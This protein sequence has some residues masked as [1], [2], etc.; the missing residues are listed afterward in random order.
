MQ[1][2][3]KVTSLEYGHPILFLEFFELLAKIKCSWT[4]KESRASHSYK[5]W[6]AL[7]LEY[8]HRN[9]QVSTAI[10]T[11]RFTLIRIRMRHGMKSYLKMANEN[12]VTMYFFPEPEKE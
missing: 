6:L 2:L 10:E 9:S 7:D 11:P 4:F 12:F 5:L 1:P 8:D 3:I